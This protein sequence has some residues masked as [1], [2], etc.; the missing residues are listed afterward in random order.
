MGAVPGPS[1]GDLVVLTDELV[2]VGMP[3]GEGRLPHSGKGLQALAIDLLPRR[4]VDGC[5]GCHQLVCN[6]E[7]APV[8][9]LIHETS[10]QRLV[11]LRHLARLLRLI[12][13]A[14][15]ARPVPL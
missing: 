11:L 6:R 8:P 7:I 3:V 12:R 5:V 9:E 13:W 4:E 1:F 10:D 15:V 2:S 14:S